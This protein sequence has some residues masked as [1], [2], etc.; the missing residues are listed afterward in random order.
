VINNDH[1]KY[2][3]L[4]SILSYPI[5]LYVTRSKDLS[6]LLRGLLRRFLDEPIPDY[7]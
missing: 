3:I 6:D 1:Y 5:I 4:Y 7:T 2:N